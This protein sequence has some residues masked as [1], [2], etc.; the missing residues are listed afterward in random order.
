MKQEEQAKPSLMKEVKQRVS[1]RVRA[2]LDALSPTER[3]HVVMG[4]LGILAVLLLYCIWQTVREISDSRKE[5]VA[6]VIEHIDQPI[7][8]TKK[9]YSLTNENVNGKGR[10]EGAGTG[11]GARRGLGQLIPGGARQ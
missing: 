2:R 1:G 8:I 6:I 9:D 7:V 11:A 3:L 4:M 5:G 10:N